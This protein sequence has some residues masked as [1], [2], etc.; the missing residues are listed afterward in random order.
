M[1]LFLKKNNVVVV[2]FLFFPLYEEF[3]QPRS[4]K[5]FKMNSSKFTSTE[6][7]YFH[8]ECRGIQRNSLN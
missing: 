8:H 3:F 7:R 4:V 2:F 6:S 1:G 5:N